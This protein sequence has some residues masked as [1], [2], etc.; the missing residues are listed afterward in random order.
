MKTAACRDSFACEG[1]VSPGSIVD[2]DNLSTGCFY[3][4]G[5]C[6][7]EA[8]D[9]AAY[10]AVGTDDDKKLAYCNGMVDGS[11]NSCTF[12]KG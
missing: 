8:A 1:A 3:F 6:Y 5:T 12:I 2:C 9:C 7:F 11:S 4:G 10:T